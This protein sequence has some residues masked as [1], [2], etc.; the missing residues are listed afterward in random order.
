MVKGKDPNQCHKC[1]CMRW[2][3]HNNRIRFINNNEYAFIRQGCACQTNSE[4]EYKYQRDQ[5]MRRPNQARG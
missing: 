2:E 3:E 1:E 4:K 5:G